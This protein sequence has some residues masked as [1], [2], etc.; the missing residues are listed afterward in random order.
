[1]DVCATIYNESSPS[2]AS[3]NKQTVHERMDIGTDTGNDITPSAW[4]ATG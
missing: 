4:K 3:A 1:M 2:G